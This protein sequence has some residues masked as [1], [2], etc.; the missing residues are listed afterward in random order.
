MTPNQLEIGA[1]DGRAPNLMGEAQPIVGPE[2]LWAN[3]AYH[4]RGDFFLGL[5]NQHGMKLGAWENGM[6]IADAVGDRNFCDC[7]Q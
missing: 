6:K 4:L 7:G 2:K 3:W 5:T 1:R